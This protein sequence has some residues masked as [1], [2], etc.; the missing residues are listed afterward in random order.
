MKMNVKKLFVLSASILALTSCAS[1]DT[2]SSSTS[3]GG[4]GSSDSQSSTS[5]SSDSSSGDSASSS[6]SGSTDS[7]GDAASSSSGTSSSS[8]DYQYSYNTYLSTSPSTWNN[9]TWETSD[10]GYISGF[11][12][13]GLYDVELNDDKTGYN[14]VAEMASDMPTSTTDLT[15]EEYNTYYSETGNITANMVWDIPLNKNACWE[16]GT[17]I[18][19]QDYVDSM[20]L[21]LSSEYANYRADSYYSSSFVLVNAENFYKQGRQTIE[22]AYS[23]LDE[24]TGEVPDDS[25]YYYLNLGKGNKAYTST[26][27]SNADDSTNFYAVLNQLPSSYGVTEEADRIVQAWCYYLWKSIDHASSSHSSSWESVDDPNDVSSSMMEDD[28]VDMDLDVFDTGFTDYETG[29]TIYV[30][31]K[32]DPNGYWEEDNLERYT[33]TEIQ[34]DLRTCVSAFGNN[35]GMTSKSWAWKLPLFTKVYTYNGEDIDMSEVGIRKLDDYTLRLYFAQSISGLDLKFS[36]TSNW[37][38]KVDLYKEL[39]IELSTGYKATRY[40]TAS[41]D[42]YMSYGPYRLESFSSSNIHIVKNEKWYG[43]TDGK[44]EGQYQMEE[45]NTRIISQHTSAMQEFLAGRLDDMDLNVDEV[46]I[47]GASRR[48]T[49]TYESYTQKISFNSDYTKLKSRQSSGINKTV[50]SNKDFREGLSLSLNRRQFASEATSGSEPFT[51]LLNDLYLANNATGQS[52]RSTEQGESVYGMVYGSLGGTTIGEETALSERAYGYNE[53][54]AIE[55]VKQGI[56]NELQSTESGHLEPNDTITIE[57]RVYDDESRNTIAAV[58]FM[59]T[60]W[61]TLISKAVAGLQEDGVLSESESIGFA[62]EVVKDQDYYN[63][64]TNG[65]YD[66]IFSIWGGAAIN[67]C[68]LMDVYCSVEQTNCCEYGFKGKQNTVMLDIDANGDGSIA[69]DGTETKSFDA[70][71]TYMQEDSSCDDAAL[72][73]GDGIPLEGQEEAWETA[74]N[75]K[76]NILAGLEAGILN[77]FEAIPLVA[78]GTTSL[79]GYKVEYGSSTYISLIGY[80]GIRS[81]TF[82]YTNDQWT[83]FCNRYS[84]NLSDL[85]KL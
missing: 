9:H 23:Y 74:H 75:R 5:G 71:N 22:P 82:N 72:V 10:E 59:R 12:E 3:G 36:L 45:L 85:Y 53:T 11:T 26:I 20:E 76:F 56:K 35:R 65:G 24:N 66:M 21:Q 2:P 25:G 84:N 77:R 47:Y 43:W 73:D 7:S 27:F 55:Y 81:M 40:A 44:H 41:A 15:D 69:T 16:D 58:N 54:L 64:A 61:T 1:G 50:L 46:S 30:M 33:L 28:N 18:T 31:K 17:P 42:N 13:M 4:S 48:A 62:L 52:Y 60:T 49:I 38:V 57:F 39:T 51:G 37:L 29:E 78:R 34:N 14:F 70:W 8:G 32:I 67:P 83:E 68:G 6:T 80:G 19:A 79:L 63:T